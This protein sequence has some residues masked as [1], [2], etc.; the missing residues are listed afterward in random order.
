MLPSAPN[1]PQIYSVGAGQ[2]FPVDFNMKV[3]I[4]EDQDKESKKNE[5]KNQIEREILQPLNALYMRLDDQRIQIKKLKDQR[6]KMKANIENADVE[7]ME[8]EEREEY[9]T[10]QE[11]YE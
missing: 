3:Q 6:D 5:R 9:D 7:N 10:Q 8:D 2:R 1:V 4:L 11:V